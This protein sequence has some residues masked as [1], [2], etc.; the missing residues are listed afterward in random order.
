MTDHFEEPP[1]KENE[2]Y[3]RLI[4]AIQKHTPYPLSDEE[5]HEAA[6]N[7]IAYHRTLL[8]MHRLLR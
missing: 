8:E 1:M 2:A 4:D 5:K 3:Q 7:L 6:R